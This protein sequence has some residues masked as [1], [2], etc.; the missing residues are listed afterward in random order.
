MS[1]LQSTG[2]VQQE[3]L[4]QRVVYAMRRAIVIGE[5]EPGTHLK[6]P[7]LAQRFGVSRLPVREA[8]VQLEREGLVRSEPRR[9]AFV[10]GV[11]EQA[12]SDIYECRLLLES[13]ALRRA[14][15]RI[16]E[17]GVAALAT[18]MDQME[19]GVAAGQVPLV[20]TCDMAFHR[21]IIYL[22]GSRALATAWEPLT[23]LIETALGIAE[24]TVPDLPTAV[25]GHRGILLALQQRDGEGAVL[26][27]SAH[28]PGGEKLVLDAIRRVREGRQ[29]A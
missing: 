14:A 3:A 29:S 4:W 7:A 22:S 15:A 25:G 16:D 5:L 12:I 1:E 21:L 18:L 26:L 11:T 6:E 8:I 20:A 27:M 19:A 17:Q 10:V 23:P 28:L 2:I 9:G 13:C 24:A